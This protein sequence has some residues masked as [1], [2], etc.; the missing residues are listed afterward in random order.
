MFIYSPGFSKSENFEE[1]VKEWFGKVCV[2]VLVLA[3]EKGPQEDVGCLMH[4]CVH[5]CVC[6]CGCVTWNMA[7]S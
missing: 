1:L 6:D 4:V 5:A 7:G 3:A 2:V